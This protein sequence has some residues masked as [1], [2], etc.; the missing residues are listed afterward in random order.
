MK[1]V[2]FGGSGFIGQKIVEKLIQNGQQVTS[3]SR[4]GQAVNLTGTWIDQV[5]WVASDILVD[6][7]WQ[8]YVDQADWVIDA[9]GI[10][11]ENRRKGLTYEKFMIEPVRKITDYLKNNQQTSRFLFISANKMPVILRKYMLA[12]Y[13]AEKIVLAQNR[14]NTIIYPGMVYDRARLYSVILAAPLN[15]SKQLPLLKKLL[16]AYIPVRRDTLADEI[17]KVINGGSSS[18]QRRR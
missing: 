7:R 12:K 6:D 4:H 16:A 10:L 18:Y 13:A 5:E 1:I 14:H 8:K 9:I 3:I 11:F 15:V 2:V 17:V